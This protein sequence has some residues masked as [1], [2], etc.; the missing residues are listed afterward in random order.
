MP[1]LQFSYILPSITIIKILWLLSADWQQKEK[2]RGVSEMTELSWLLQKLLFLKK[3]RENF[4]KKTQ[5]ALMSLSACEV[6]VTK[7]LREKKKLS[8]TLP[9]ILNKT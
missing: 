6:G 9:S 1:F 8:K 7:S 3:E 2:F 5:T 4:Q